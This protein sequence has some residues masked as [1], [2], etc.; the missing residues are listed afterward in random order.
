MQVG[1]SI[2]V[3]IIISGI[4][5][6]VCLSYYQKNRHTF[7]IDYTFEKTIKDKSGAMPFY[8]EILDYVLKEYGLIVSTAQV[9]E[10]KR[11]YGLEI[12]DCNNLEADTSPA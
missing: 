9:A 12:R 6:T 5:E 3:F 7:S 10:E 11:Q 1:A 4:V 2:T 8:R